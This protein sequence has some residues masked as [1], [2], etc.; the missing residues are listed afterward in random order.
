MP[1]SASEASNAAASR[2]DSQTS[3]AG[4]V[5]A[6]SG[7]RA[8]TLTRRD[9]IVLTIASAAIAAV[10]AGVRNERSDFDVSGG[11]A[12]AWLAGRNPYQAVGPGREVEWQFPMLYPFT[13]VI[14]VA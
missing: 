6:N 4:V 1:T 10:I 11:G 5:R 2:H 13:A 14:A 7:S 12:R 9:R 8:F 3:N